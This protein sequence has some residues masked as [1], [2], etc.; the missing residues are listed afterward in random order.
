MRKAIYIFVILTIISHIAVAQ[1]DLSDIVNKNADQPKKEFVTATFKG[2]RII[3]AQTIETAK[4]HN[5]QFNIQ[6]RFGDI[7]GT[8]GGI[9]TFFG[10][11]AATDIRFSFDYGITDRLQVGVGRSRGIY[12]YRE[13]YDGNLK[14]KLLRQTTNGS[15]P[16][17][18]T[19]Y[20]VA[21]ATGSRSDT[22]Q[23]S[24]T[25][26][27][28]FSYRMSYVSQMIIARKFT[29]GFSLELLPTY[30]HRNYVAYDDVNDMF[31]LGAG[32]RL[33]LTKRFA[34]ITDYFHD[35]R[36]PY[37]AT[38]TAK[39]NRL[40]YDPLS[41][42]VEIETGG[43]VFQLTFTNATGILENTF[44]PFTTTSWTKGQFR[45][46]FNL[47]RNFVIGGKNY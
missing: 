11:D 18:I 23:T 13:L 42:G 27:K 14:F 7:A 32:A 31:F 3:N 47:T 24:E 1:D 35:F 40:H 25:H 39:T 33:K 30:M 16:L 41:V 17:S 36:S 12:P 26:F 29:P 9:H 4:K 6:H 46:G 38:D 20:G 19:L 5:M 34:I 15:M 8:G 44:L 45:W 37:A 28:N 22:A 10:L 43:H 21:A 2:L